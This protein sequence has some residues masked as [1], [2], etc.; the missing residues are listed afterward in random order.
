M[1]LSVTLPDDTLIGHTA[2]YN[3]NAPARS[4]ELMLMIGGSNVGQGYGTV[5]T[6]MIVDFGFRE[7]GLNR[8]GLGIW[9]YN[10]R[11]LRTFSRAGFREEGR[12]RQAGF[13]DGAFHDRILMS[14]LAKEHFGN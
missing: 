4:A 9:A 11:A 8:I 5:A 14:L 12:H 3:F 6:K 7:M 2:L 13:H 10:E 1:G